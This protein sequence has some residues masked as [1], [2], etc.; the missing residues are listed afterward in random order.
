MRTILGSPAGR[1][2]LA[3]MVTGQVVMAAV[4]TS[5]PVQLHL[6]HHGL[7]VVGLVLAAHTLG[8]FVL[9]PVT[10]RLVDVLGAGPVMALGLRH[11]AWSRRW[12]PHPAPSSLRRSVCSCSATDG[13]CAS[14][15]AARRSPSACP[16][17]SGR[18]GGLRRGRRV[19][20]GRG[21]HPDVDHGPR[22]RRVVDADARGR[23][24]SSSRRPSSCSA[25]GSEPRLEPSDELPGRERA[26]AERPTVEQP[27]PTVGRAD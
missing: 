18:R 16:R 4:M 23:R 21:R 26:L 5:V 10:G 15:A 14:S 24:H 11:A 19:D 7:D 27:E 2:G 9:S 20:L 22:A 3:V 6:H 8:M 17:S 13:T 25:T 1:D 12:W